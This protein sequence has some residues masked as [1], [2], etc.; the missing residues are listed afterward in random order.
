MAMQP[1]VVHRALK[2]A[3]VVGSLLAAIN[4]GG[5][6][7]SG[8]FGMENAIQVGLTYLVPYGVSTYSSVGA[9]REGLKKNQ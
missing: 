5:A 3:A 7:L 4:H 2:V 6:L 1:S 9:L 8:M